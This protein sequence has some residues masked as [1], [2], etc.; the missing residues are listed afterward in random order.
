[1]GLDDELAALN[2]IGIDVNGIEIFSGASPFVNWDGIG[3]GENATWTQVEITIPA[4]LLNQGRN[5]ITFANL[6]P[7]A[8]F[9][10]PPYVLLSE[11]TLD[12]PGAR[13]VALAPDDARR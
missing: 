10:A 3:D 12:A 4:E 7:S 9:S 6:S 11:A 1:M 13:V 8:N 2:P 5:E